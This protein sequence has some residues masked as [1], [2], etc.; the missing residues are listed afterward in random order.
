M[1]T[2]TIAGRGL[3]YDV[4]LRRIALLDERDREIVRG[5]YHTRVKHLGEDVGDGLV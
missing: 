2:P 5:D 4:E 1:S 3:V